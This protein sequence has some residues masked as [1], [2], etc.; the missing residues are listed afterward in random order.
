[1][2]I[3]SGCREEWVIIGMAMIQCISQHIWGIIYNKN[4]YGA[5][6]QMKVAIFPIAMNQSS[7][8][9]PICC[10]AISATLQCLEI[11]SQVGKIACRA[12]AQ[13]PDVK[14]PCF[15]LPN[16][17]SELSPAELWFVELAYPACITDG[18]WFKD[19]I[20]LSMWLNRLCK[21]SRVCIEV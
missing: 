1:M 3:W 18:L 14:I 6:I 16:F 13:I 2:S 10:P 4:C 7:G 21:H 9:N 5:F 8:Y 17:R 19:N 11:P 20:K 15:G 12:C